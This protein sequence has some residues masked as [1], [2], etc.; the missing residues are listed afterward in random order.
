MA[1]IR[2]HPKHGVNPTIPTCFY[3]GE[4][5]NEIALLGAAYR[6]EAPMKGVVLDQKPCDKCAGYMKQG[7]ILISVKDGEDGKPNPYR[8]G[9]WAVIKDEA[10]RRMVQPD[11][12]AETIIARRAAFV[13][14]EAWAA[15]GLTPQ[16]EKGG[17]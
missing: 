6:G 15:L 7:V 5:K 13:P 12:L 3:C 8:T 11:D 2:L 4:D 14:D 17:G 16:P 1:G 10:I 9:G